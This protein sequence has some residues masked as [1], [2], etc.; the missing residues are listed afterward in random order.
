MR[1]GTLPHAFHCKASTWHTQLPG[2]IHIMVGGQSNAT[3]HTGGEQ[4]MRTTCGARELEVHEMTTI[5]DDDPNFPRL[6][7]RKKKKGLDLSIRNWL[8][9]KN[10]FLRQVTGI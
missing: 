1:G 10:S 5:E 4:E 7:N 9:E 6:Y 8:N 3:L 2:V